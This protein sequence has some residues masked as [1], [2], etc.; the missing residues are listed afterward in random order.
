M[1][2]S[3][4]KPP[5]GTV[6]SEVNASPRRHKATKSSVVGPRQPRVVVCLNEGRQIGCGWKR[7]VKARQSA[8]MRH[9]EAKTQKKT[10]FQTCLGGG[11]SLWARTL[12]RTGTKQV[13]SSLSLSSFF[14]FFCSTS[15]QLR[16]SGP[17][18]SRGAAPG[19]CRAAAIVCR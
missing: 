10:S 16:P 9:D 6:Q 4:R 17:K 1:A 8:L 2:P 13:H 5:D 14:F 12:D 19:V 11:S 18:E 15:R 3:S 7:A